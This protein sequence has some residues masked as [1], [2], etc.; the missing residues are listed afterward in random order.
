MI[1]SSW[2][3]ATWSAGRTRTSPTRPGDRG[4]DDV[5][6][7][8]RLEGDDRVAGRDGRARRRRG[9]SGRRRASGRRPRPG[10]RPATPWAAAA[11]AARSTSGGGARRN[12][13]LRPARSTWTVSP[14]RTEAKAGRGSRRRRR[15]PRPIGA[16]VRLEPDRARRVEPPAAGPRI[17]RRPGR[18]RAPRPRCHASSG[19]A[20]RSAQSSGG[21]IRSSVSVRAWPSRTDRLPHEPAE[22]PQVR[23][24]ARGRRS[25]RARAPAGRRR[26]PDRG[27]ARRSWRASG[28]TGRR[29]RRPARSRHRRGCPRRP[30]SGAPRSGRSRAGTGLGVLGVQPDLDRVARSRP[31]SDLREPERLAGGDPQLVGDEVAAGD[32]LGDRVLD[33]EPRVHLEEGR[34]RRASSRGT[35][36]CRR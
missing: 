15:R 33:L 22:E 26:S 3:R 20:V 13:T 10:R 11:R 5:L 16:A 18:R 8:H 14:T 7:L 32:H 31:T 27:R 9:R 24:R 25:R 2:P 1:A 36:T 28:R 34:T 21:Q 30:A 29:P 19:I 35:R 12:G 4:G 17:A 23:R 6:H